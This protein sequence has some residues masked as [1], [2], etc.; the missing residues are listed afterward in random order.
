MKQLKKMPKGC[1][2]GDNA[3]A[4]IGGFRLW[5]KGRPPT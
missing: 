3:N 1:R 5:M 2:P 4:F